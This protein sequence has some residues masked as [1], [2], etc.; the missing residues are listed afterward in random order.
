MATNKVYD[1]RAHGWSTRKKVVFIIGLFGLISASL[2][3]MIYWNGNVFEG[4][5]SYVR[6]EGLWAKAQK[7]A[8]FYLTQY[9]YNH[10]EADYLAY[11]EALE[12][13]SGDSKART[14]L[15]QSPP[16]KKSARDGFL[17][18]QNHPD[19]IDAMIHF[20]IK[21]QRI[22][23]MREAIDIW[24]SADKKIDALKIIGEQIRDEIT[25]SR[26][27]NE[28]IADLRQHMQQLN[29]ELHELETL[30]SLKLSEGARW[31][32]I[33]A[34]QISLL[35]LVI[36]VG[37]GLLVSR[38]IITSIEKSE[39]RLA[40]SESRF[41]S[42]KESDTIG[43]ISWRL[44]GMVEEANDLFLNML[45]LAQ[46]DIEEGAV[47]WRD[48]TPTEFHAQDQQAIDELVV[49]GRCEPYEKALIHKQG[50]WVPVYIGAAL[51][52]GS[53][54]QGIAYVMDLSER[55]K[56]EQQLKLAA[57]VFDFSSEGIM[58]TDPSVR[59]VSVNQTLCKM[60]G[61]DQEELLGKP[62]WI[63]QS[64]Y[65]STEQ[66]QYMW[67]SLNQNGQWQGDIVDRTKNGALL[68]MRISI[69]QVKDSDNQITHYVAIL[70]D[71]SER[72]AEE[73]H[74]RHI[75]HH[76]PLTDLPNRILFNDRLERAIK[77][78]ARNNTKLGILFLD[79][80][81]FKPV[82]DL[83]GHKTGDRLLQSVAH[84]IVR[85]VRETDTVTR[86]GG[87]EF[88]I[89]LEDVTDLH[90]VDKIL[91]HTVDVI[92][93]TYLIDDRMI[94]IGVSAGMSIY[95]NDGTDIKTLLDRADKA[96]Y[97]NKKNG[98]GS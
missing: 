24:Q 80:D 70:S 22:S 66:Y 44:D 78:A 71:I 46:A 95:P 6:G 36:F 67:D 97:E 89:L 41:R 86:L 64:G 17:Q 52:S 69:S 20:F 31:V 13:I 42:L 59:I 3:G 34:L 14:A 58:I 62:P 28:K 82:N 45:G 5:R 83:F 11:L 16:D 72:K 2:V 49:Q 1:L 26:R 10:A 47:N 56:A 50:Y 94:D 32:K 53:R 54:E 84:R 38:Q 21:F 27:D 40:L 15:F 73:E 35:L 37:I 25:D 90:M 63:L 19:D 29:N 18:G 48:I 57:T 4:V 39:K 8:V 12:I 30:F 23:Y 75:A 51:L 96:M 7:D 61:Y 98:N 93:K 87:D 60:T 79:L 43:I 76:D 65:I 88:A 92:S 85:S 33:T 77:K 91:K 81:K 55:K 74:L 68:P 9:S